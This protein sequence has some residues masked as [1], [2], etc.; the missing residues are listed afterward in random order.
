MEFKNLILDKCPDCSKGLVFPNKNLFSFHLN[1]MNDTCPVC[2]TAF[3][4]EPGFYWGAMYVSY[5]LNV[6]EMFIAYFVCRL[7]GTGTYDWIN[8]IVMISVILALSPF[9][10]R[11]SRLI[12]LYIFS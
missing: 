2:H 1:K 5:A 3:H 6:A 8:L 11:L 7:F 9:N 12:W 4:K 10:F